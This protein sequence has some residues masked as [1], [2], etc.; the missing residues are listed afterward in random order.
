MEAKKQMIGDYIN[1]ICKLIDE[2]YP[3]VINEE[4]IQKAIAMF[5]DSPDDLTIIKAKINELAQQ[6]VK[7]YLKRD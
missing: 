3:G 2:Q 7:N 5:I 6:V 1:Y 4:Q